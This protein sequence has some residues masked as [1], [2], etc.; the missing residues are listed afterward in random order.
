MLKLFSGNSSTVAAE[1]RSKLAS[2][3]EEAPGVI[4][5][6]LSLALIAALA[7]PVLVTFLLMPLVTAYVL[8][9]PRYWVYIGETPLLRAHSYELVNKVSYA[10]E[11]CGEAYEERQLPSPFALRS[12]S[13]AVRMVEK[14]V[15]R[16]HR[17]SGTVP[18]FSHRHKH[19]K[20]HAA[21]VVARL[22]A[23]EGQVDNKGYIAI[24]DIA[25]LL[26]TIAE[27]YTQGRVGALLD[28]DDITDEKLAG[29]RPARDREP[30]RLCLFA[31]LVTAGAIGIASLKLSDLA[32]TVA[33]G[34]VGL[35]ALAVV[36]RREAMRRLSI[37]SPF[38]G[39]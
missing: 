1:L 32:S 19:L 7:L 12:L 21:R 35:F 5:G 15:R 38:G 23:S 6:N 34:G 3:A 22:K 26:L 36:Y 20:R 25:E 14:E 16:A 37:L 27:R 29:V 30:L 33:V 4:I 9:T 39:Q 2:T 8:R 24:R 18:F 31:T 28:E 13:D 17:T 10:L 11:A